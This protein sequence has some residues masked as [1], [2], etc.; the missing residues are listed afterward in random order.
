M[1]PRGLLL[2]GRGVLPPLPLCR[3][4][5]V[6][7]LSAGLGVAG[8]PS[9]ASPFG[10]AEVPAQAPLRMDPMCGADA[11]RRMWCPASARAALAFHGPYPWKR[12]VHADL[13]RER[14]RAAQVG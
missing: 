7:P 9:E 6:R 13:R 11:M 5:A 12:G 8:E 4:R 2:R 1:T 14:D 10:A 3:G